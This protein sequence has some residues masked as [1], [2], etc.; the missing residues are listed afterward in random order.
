MRILIVGANGQD[1]Y[2]AMEQYH[3]AG[4]EILGVVRSSQTI[5]TRQRV[6]KLPNASVISTDLS[7]RKVTF[8]LL[9]TFK[10][11]RIVNFAALHANSI[12]MEKLEQDHALEIMKTNFQINENLL[13]WV[14]NNLKT[15]ISVALSSQMYSS[16]EGIRFI[17]E[18]SDPDPKTI[19]GKTK[20]RSFEIIKKFRSDSS[21]FV[22]GAILFNHTSYKSKP[23]FLFQELAT[24]L[25][26]YSRGN[27]NDIKIR[28]FESNIDISYAPEVVAGVINSLEIEKP[29]DFVFS[30]GKTH[31]VISIF[32]EVLRELDI[33]ISSENLIS[34]FPNSTQG[35]LVGIPKK[36]E[37]LLQWHHPTP[38][39]K[40]LIEVFERMKK[41]S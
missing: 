9:N 14:S 8:E 21:V 25:L 18:D 23:G 6:S 35:I 38:P 17:D 41:T 15:R 30:N 13:M 32:R 3:Q 19:Y 26:E 7:E 12:N 16:T 31:T 11:H 37:K 10:P 36:A 33:N 24:Q 27:C 39:N 5:N 4:H 20:L 1:G 22:S 29:Q 2:F 28:N 34:T 40:I